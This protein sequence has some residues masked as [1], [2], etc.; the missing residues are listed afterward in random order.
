MACLRADW[1]FYWRKSARNEIIFC[2]KHIL[3][4]QLA[5]TE[6]VRITRDY[7][8]NRS[9]EAVDLNRLARRKGKAFS[10]LVEVRG[11]ENIKAALAEGKGAILCSAHFGSHVSCFALL[12]A[13]GFPMTLVG[14]WPS[15]VETK[16]TL[17]A[18]IS[19][20]I[21]PMRLTRYF[22]RENIEPR[23]GNFKVAVRAARVLRE[24]E[25]LATFIDAPAIGKDRSRALS[26]DF[27]NHKA[28]VL[29]GA[30]VI[31]KQTGAPILMTFIHRSLDWRHQA[32]EILPPISTEGD[33][34]T[35]LQRCLTIADAQIRNDPAQWRSLRLSFLVAL[36]LISGDLQAKENLMGG[37]I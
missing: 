36:G 6:R 13:L 32:I 35:V 23:P 2:L 20:L 28:L 37:W 31:A 5:P 22:R 18:Q 4:N 10:R 29:P 7:F 34:K 11:I 14:R 25:L 9:C 26:V 21:S 16:S 17:E 30:A 19:R 15:I 8:R 1:C 12:A 24:N 33:V 3:G 27:L